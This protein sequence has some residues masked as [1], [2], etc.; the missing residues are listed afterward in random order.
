MLVTVYNGAGGVGKTSL[1]FGISKDK[2]YKYSTN[3]YINSLIPLSILGEENIT[4]RK[5]L[6]KDTKNTV[7]DCGGFID[8][9]IKK[10]IKVSDRLIVPIEISN[11]SIVVLNKLFKEFIE[12]IE[13][14]KI[15]IVLNKVENEKDIKKVLPSL[16][17]IG[18]LESQIVTI[19]KSKVFDNIME[20]N[21]GVIE[22]YNKNNTTKHHYKNVSED[23]KKLLE[24]V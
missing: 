24:R 19:R 21:K 7:F 2:K 17:K 18:V 8:K 23:F 5:D 22:L 6:N 13:Q 12:I 9:S 20:E 10:I 3:D 16:K 11:K 14:D 15:I 1:S 4:D